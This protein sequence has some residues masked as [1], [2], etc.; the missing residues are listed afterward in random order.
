MRRSITLEWQVPPEPAALWAVRAVQAFAALVLLHWGFEWALV[1]FAD[2]D[3]GSALSL[4]GQ[5]AVEGV[6]SGYGF[7]TG[8]GVAALCALG[9]LFTLV[10]WL[11]RRALRRHA[12]SWALRVDGEGWHWARDDGRGAGSGM[13]QVAVAF[14]PWCLLRA[15]AQPGQGQSAWIWLRPARVMAT[16]GG[17]G[18]DAPHHRYLAG[19]RLRTVLNWT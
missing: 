6:G 15:V 9:V 1:L 7:V 2:A 4:Q 8:V 3:A 13:V 19:T 18:G 5:G 16:H 10:G 12:S 11:A 14:G 17:A